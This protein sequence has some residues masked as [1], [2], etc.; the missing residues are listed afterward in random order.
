VARLTDA[1]ATGGSAPAATEDT[2]ALAD[3]QVVD[4]IR[5][6]RGGVLRPLDRV[7][8]H[9]PAIADGWNGLLGAIRDR[10]SLPADLR[11]LVILRVAVLNAAEYEWAAHVPVA[12]RAGVT[13][14]QLDALRRPAVGAPFSPVSSAVLA[15]TDAMTRQV[16][17]AQPVFDALRAAFDER[18]LVELTATVA[19]YN[20]VSRFLVALEVGDPAEV[21]S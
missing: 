8:L 21:V 20:M 19:A 16:R 17:V 2:E 4:R 10:S 5:R 3:A 1:V 11:E 13:P 18:Q 12:V 15:Y 14:D 7:L 9:A 6:R